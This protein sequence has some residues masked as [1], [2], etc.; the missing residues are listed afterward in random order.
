MLDRRYPLRD[1]LVE[2]RPW[3]G[4]RCPNC[5]DIAVVVGIQKRRLMVEWRG[6]Y[7]IER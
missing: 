5:T 7:E 6:I 2:A 1:R 4:V 3:M